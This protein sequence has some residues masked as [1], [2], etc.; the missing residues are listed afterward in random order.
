MR[1]YVNNADEFEFDT[2]DDNEVTV[3]EEEVSI[4]IN[5]FDTVLGERDTTLDKEIEFEFC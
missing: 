5:L 2:V 4:E 1:E 3:E